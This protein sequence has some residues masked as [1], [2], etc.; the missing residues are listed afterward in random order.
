MDRQEYMKA[1]RLANKDKCKEY[2][3]K[4][5]ETH[6]DNDETKQK[7]NEYSRTYYNNVTKAKKQVTSDNTQK[8][9]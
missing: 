9:S 8:T 2:R 5:R 1:Y 3:K 6:K 4:W 7:N